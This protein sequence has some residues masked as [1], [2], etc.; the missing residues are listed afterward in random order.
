LHDIRTPH[1]LLFFG[2]CIVMMLAPYG[3]WLLGRWRR[4]F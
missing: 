4:W 3:M 1:S 2:L